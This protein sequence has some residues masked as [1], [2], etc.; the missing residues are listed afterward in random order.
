MVGPMKTA[1]VTGASAGIGREF[2]EQFAA[3][4]DNLVVVARSAERLEELK[5]HLE[6]RYKVDV[7]V[8]VADLA[9]ADD[10]N[11]GCT[12]RTA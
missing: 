9:E 8:L 10:L 5:K 2:C 12:R 11:R 4:G 6:S 7:E 3:R 1:L